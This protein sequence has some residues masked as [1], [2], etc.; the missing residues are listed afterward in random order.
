[1]RRR[2]DLAISLITRPPVIFLDEPTTGLDLRSRQTMWDVVRKLVA[3]GTTILLT[4]QYL[5]EAD[6]LADSIAVLDRGRDRLRRDAGRAQAPRRGRAGRADLRRRR[7]R[8]PAA[9][10]CSPATA[11]TRRVAGASGQRAV[12]RHRRRRQAPA[13]PAR[14]PRR[15]GRPAGAAPA[16]AR[17]RLPLP[18]W[19]VT[20][21]TTTT[22][23][24]ATTGQSSAGRS[25]TPSR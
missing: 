15:A 9:P 7:R 5:E 8:T 23:T 4:T 25:A 16:V 21:M 13:R 10:R 6:Q 11:S 19:T 12:G 24:P 14:R 1:M 20:S 17:R 22:I 18:D 2:L 3:D